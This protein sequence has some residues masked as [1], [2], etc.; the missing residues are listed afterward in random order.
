VAM[1]ICLLLEGA[2]KIVGVALLQMRGGELKVL[3]EGAN[4]IVV[5][6]L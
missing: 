6:L 5:A 1:K 2:N 3:L 4:K